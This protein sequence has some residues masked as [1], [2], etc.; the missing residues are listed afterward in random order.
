MFFGNFRTLQDQTDQALGD[1]QTQ[2]NQSENELSKAIDRNRCLE[3]KQIQLDNQVKECKQEVN[4]LRANM[5]RLDQ[6][7]D[8]L[9]VKKKKKKTDLLNNYCNF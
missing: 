8:K 5:A 2:L 3:Q 9:L 6:E 4:T 1:V 7:K